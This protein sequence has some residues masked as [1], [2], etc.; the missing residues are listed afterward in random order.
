MA[1]ISNTGYLRFLF[2]PFPRCLSVKHGNFVSTAYCFNKFFSSIYF[3]FFFTLMMDA[4]ANN[5]LGQRFTYSITTEVCTDTPVANQRHD[6][7]IQCLTKQST[8][9]FTKQTHL[10]LVDTTSLNKKRPSNYSTSTVDE[11]TSRNTN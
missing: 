7:S 11:I 10:T 9:W 6:Q 2:R 1:D 3:F 5:L 8:W 4:R